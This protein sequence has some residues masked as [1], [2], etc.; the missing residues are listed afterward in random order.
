M[1]RYNPRHELWNQCA[2]WRDVLRSHTQFTRDNPD[3]NEHDIDVLDSEICSVSTALSTS[4]CDRL[5]EF[6]AQFARV[7]LRE[8]LHHGVALQQRLDAIGHI[9]QLTSAVTG[10][11]YPPIEMPPIPYS[12]I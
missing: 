1:H 2:H 10:G 8:D 7:W 5:A 6:T 12:H 11:E 9:V 3:V 4:S